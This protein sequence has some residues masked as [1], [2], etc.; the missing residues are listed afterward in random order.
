MKTSANALRI[1]QESGEIILEH[2]E[3]KWQRR[4]YRR[5]NNEAWTLC[6]DS[7]DNF[8]NL[9]LKRHGIL[10]G[11]SNARTGLPSTLA[12]WTSYS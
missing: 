4:S 7:P 3:G 9:S 12:L 11:P 5:V 2:R 8:T 1:W 10:Q 6:F